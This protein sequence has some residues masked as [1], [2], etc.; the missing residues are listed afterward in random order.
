[1]KE[2]QKLSN[3]EIDLPAI[4]PV[5]TRYIFEKGRCSIC[6]EVS[7]QKAEGQTSIAT[8]TAGIHFGPRVRGMAA[9]LKQSLGVPYRK[10]AMLLEN[11][12]NLKVSAGA[13]A[14]SDAR[15]AQSAEA[16]LGALAFKLR[17]SELLFADETGWKVG[18][19]KAW[20]WVICSEELSYYKISS[21]RN[22]KLVDE[23]LGSDFKGRLMRDGWRSYDKRIECQMLRCLY[24][25]RHNAEDLEAKQTAGA[26]RSPR[27]FLDW[28][29]E[30]FALKKEASALSADEYHPKAQK[31]IEW[32]EWF[33]KERSYSNELNAVFARKLL[34]AED[35]ILPILKE[36]NLPATNNCAERQIRPA[37]VNR[38]ISAGNKTWRG[39]W[40]TSALVSIAA[41]C[42]QQ[43]AD[44]LEVFSKIILS[45]E[46]PVIFWNTS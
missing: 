12:W 32:F 5:V 10:T 46:K 3:I 42:R 35:Q 41:S 27:Y 39:A 18:G 19:K 25:L 43:G 38:K 11:H 15:L 34:I 14:R 9:E 21:S 8:G 20:L 2:V 40:V 23:F 17:C 26:V 24:H 28:L 31:L 4:E 45:P 33:T 13:L 7:C 29:K 30:V 36:Q 16:T 44:L 22:A 6:G 37:V 1:M